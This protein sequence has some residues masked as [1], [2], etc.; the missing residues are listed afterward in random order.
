MVRV[1]IYVLSVLVPASPV[2]ALAPRAS[3]LSL[4]AKEQAQANKIRALLSKY[5]YTL[6]REL[7]TFH[8]QTAD[9]PDSYRPADLNEIKR[10]SETW[11][12][13]FFNPE[14]VGND[15]I[16]PGHYVSTDLIGARTFGGEADP[17]LYVTVIKPN[18][19]ILDG[20]E[21]L[22]EGEA[23]FK[24][25]Q[26][27]LNCLESSEGPEEPLKDI[28]LSRASLEEWLGAFRNSPTESCRKVIIQAIAALEV[29][30]I[31]Y[32]YGAANEFANCRHNRNEAL[33]I[34]SGNAFYKNKIA[35][36]SNDKAF[37]PNR[38]GGFLKRL[39]DE[40]LKDYNLLMNLDESME[41]GPDSLSALNSNVADYENWK[42]NSI[43][44]CGPMWKNENI[45]FSY[46]EWFYTAKDREI[47]KLKYR[48]AR[49]RS[50]KIKD[51]ADYSIYL[52][53]E[54]MRGYLEMT[55]RLA[56]VSLE[57]WTA[58]INKYNQEDEDPEDPDYIKGKNELATIL[59][60]K[61]PPDSTFKM[62]SRERYEKMF[63]LLKTLNVN[64]ALAFAGFRKLGFGPRM[65]LLSL[66]GILMAV[67]GV[68]FVT[69]VLPLN[70][71][72]NYSSLVKA[73]KAAYISYL[74]DCLRQYQDE[75]LSKE[76]IA[77]GSCGVMENKDE[78]TPTD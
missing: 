40:G 66:N 38:V 63:G 11:G 34:I 59:G 16:G 36:F 44:K 7:M 28:A 76:E 2:S 49:A 58:A 12:E 53:F 24:G 19:K 70:S 35:Y 72:V 65:T 71:L 46:G 14:S 20:R 33:S 31:L 18:A 52:D 60:E 56:G 10:A 69:G 78:A 74:Q 21:E 37:D 50:K 47:L 45:K 30:A 43:Y 68:P 1:L 8:Y 54:Q 4:T 17:Q 57:V 29:D 62:S 73:N 67:N 9:T 39:Y 27:E 23:I 5:V 55:A 42:A 41:K 13:D 61:S 32:F 3:K 51:S 6:N 75:Q 64:P 77:A 22:E 25:V 48:V 26:K 15:M